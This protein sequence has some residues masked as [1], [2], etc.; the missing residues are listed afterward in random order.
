[1]RKSRWV[2][3]GKTPVI[4]TNSG[5]IINVLRPSAK[6]VA[7]HDIV[8]GLS[9]EGRFV[10]QTDETISVGQ[11]TCYVVRL[12][13]QLKGDRTAQRQAFLHD[14]SE[15]YVRDIPKWFK[16][17]PAMAFYRDIEARWWKA[18]AK[19]FDL[20]VKMSPI[21]EMA[22][23]LMVRFEAREG[24]VD[25]WTCPPNY[26]DPTQIERLLV[27]NCYATNWR[28]WTRAETKDAMKLEAR[29]LGW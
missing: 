6:D 11:H 14:G 19:A 21:I 7:L 17:D 1:M 29:R 22:D 9:G 4:T 10:N 8:H 13:E 16:N 24:F 5:R 18:I 3:D 27:W 23:R 25:R 28:P 15:A 20:P 2:Q 12:V 26:P